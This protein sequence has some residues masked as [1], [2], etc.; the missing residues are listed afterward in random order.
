MIY[1]LQSFIKHK[2]VDNCEFYRNK[3][4]NIAI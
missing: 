1:Y 4:M 2:N 3:E